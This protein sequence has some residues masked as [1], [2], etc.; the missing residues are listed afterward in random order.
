MP[1]LRFFQGKTYLDI[2]T[3]T[4]HWFNLDPESMTIG[5][6]G[7]GVKFST[8]PD[9]TQKWS[10][11]NSLVPSFEATLRFYG[12]LIMKNPKANAVLTGLTA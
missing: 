5:D 4:N 11:V 12:N 8:A 2:D 7:G 9:R 6:L 3:W 10:R 1:F